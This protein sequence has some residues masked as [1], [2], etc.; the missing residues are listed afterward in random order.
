[1]TPFPRSDYSDLVRYEPGRRPVSL[2]LSDN[3]NLWGAHPAALALLRSATEADLARYPELYADAL[4]EA[5]GKRFGV[6][7]KCVTTGAGSDDVLDSTFRAS[8]GYG[9][10]V[11][12]AS[13]T[14]SMVEPFARMNGMEPRA[15]PWPD[16]ASDPGK[17]LEGGPALIYVCRPNNPTG[18]TL[19]V[20]WIERLLALREADGP[21]VILDEAYADFAGESFISRAPN[22]PKTLVVRTAS[23]AYGLA[24]L[25]CGFAVAAPEV[26]LEVD[27]SRGPYKVSGLAAAATAAAVADECGWMARTIAACL[28]NR[29]RLFSALSDRGLSP[30]PSHAN[31]LLFP[32]P[33]GSATAD[34]AELRRRGVGVR[35]FQGIPDM[36]EGLRV[37]IG[38]WA[39]ME[40]FLAAVDGA[41][42][43]GS[44]AS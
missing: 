15:V 26:I 44:E 23:K 37:T 32:A 8:A 43:L 36:D 9:S 40:R 39:L 5:V 20:S 30:L 25:R 11:N 41:F 29:E 17:L 38:P 35:P 6:A 1:M 7:P 13:P 24:G 3:T 10:T 31:F 28:R 22:V 27:K 16:V 18:E 12:F 33:T 4:C 2:D 14:F 19:P 42:G 21:L 34:A